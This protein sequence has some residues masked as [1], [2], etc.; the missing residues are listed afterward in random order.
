MLSLS[1]G[2]QELLLRLT[3]VILLGALAGRFLSGSFQAD[4]G[5]VVSTGM[6]PTVCVLLAVADHGLANGDWLFER[7]R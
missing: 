5:L 6:I 4:L 1:G 7:F 2:V 3:G